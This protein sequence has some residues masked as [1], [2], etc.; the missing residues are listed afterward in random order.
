[1]NETDELVPVRLFWQEETQ[2]HD[3]SSL[4]EGARVFTLYAYQPVGVCICEARRSY[5]LIDVSTYID[6]PDYGALTEDEIGRV[7]EWEVSI[8]HGMF[9]YAYT[10]SIDRMEGTWEHF[11]VQELA[12]MVDDGADAGNILVYIAYDLDPV[13]KDY[14]PLPRVGRGE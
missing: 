5:E 10:S 1:M 14:V 12:Q 13:W 7:H 3:V 9:S 2:S 8:E 4:P 11:G 6:L